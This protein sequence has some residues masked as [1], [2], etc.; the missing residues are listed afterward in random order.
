MALAAVA[1]TAG[2]L[3]PPRA[4]KATVELQGRANE[5]ILRIQDDGIGMDLAR[6]SNGDGLGLAS[7]AERARLVGGEI[8]I[9]AQSSGGTRIDARVP[10]SDA[11]S[12]PVES[13]EVT[14]HNAGHAD[15]HS[16]TG[17]RHGTSPSL[18]RR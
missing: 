16:S 12:R 2:R 14:L 7:M 9:Q 3:S 15:M 6:V 1:M 8:A 18:A 17:D 4:K 13:H 10:L 5:M 11:R